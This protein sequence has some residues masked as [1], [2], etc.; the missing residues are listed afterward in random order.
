MGALHARGQ[1][2]GLSYAALF[3]IRDNFCNGDPN[4][5]GSIGWRKGETCALQKREIS[6]CVACGNK[7]GKGETQMAAECAHSVQ[8][9][10]SACHNVNKIAAGEGKLAGIFWEERLT[11]GKL[12]YIIAA[13]DKLDDIALNIFK[14]SLS[15]N[16]FLLYTACIQ[17]RVTAQNVYF[18]FGE[19]L[20]ADIWMFFKHTTDGGQNV[21]TEAVEKQ[22][23][24]TLKIIK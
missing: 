13:H 4:C 15:S 12:A 21:T 3:Y 6:H 8:L 7:A 10:A 22:M 11:G 18:I 16:V 24:F 5:F 2:E 17:S 23:A 9:A 1:T 19:D 14:L 20:H